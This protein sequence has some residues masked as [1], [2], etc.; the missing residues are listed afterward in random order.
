MAQNRSKKRIYLD[1][2][3]TTPLAKRVKDA[4]EPYWD[5]DFGNPG[6]LYQ[7]GVIAKQAVLESRKKIA[8]ALNALP[9]EI[10]FT[11]GGTEANS[12]AIFGFVGWLEGKGMKLKDL[13]FIT[14]TIEHPSVLD[15]FGEL[16]TRG[17]QVSHVGVGETGLVKLDELKEA[18]MPNTVL[19]SIIY[20]HNEIGTIQPIS[21]IAKIIRQHQ[22]NSTQQNLGRLSG[23]MALPLFHSDASQAPLYLDINVQKLGVDFMVLDTQKIYGPK[24]VGALYL[25]GGIHIKPLFFG[26]KQEQ[27]L[28]PGT[29]NVPGIVGFAKAIEIAVEEREKESARLT[30]L[31]D[32][33]IAAILKKIRDAE[34]NG[35]PKE[36]L[37]NNVNISIPGIENEWVVIQL[38]VRGIAVGTRSACLAGDPTGSYVVR[39]LGKSQKH[40]QGS[41][42]FTLGRDTTKEE[43]E[44]VVK[45][46]SE[47]VDK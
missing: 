10:I 19:V 38:D 24:G 26:G 46:L 37:P 41:I 29:E 6:G 5:D 31:R 30:E 9:N 28:R 35:D 8:D 14:C 13:H 17:A 39:A 32:Y 2:A 15:A 36:R 21:Q 34:L 11:S 27:G 47:I 33:F 1:Y 40:S 7:E 44:Y 45:T 22:K 23:K 43:V 42:R 25:K 12:L 18:L 16:E 3:A 20:A 4:M